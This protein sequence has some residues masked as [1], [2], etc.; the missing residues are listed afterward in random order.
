M[1][2]PIRSTH[3]D[4]V[5]LFVPDRHDAAAWYFDVLGLVPIPG[6]EHWSED[7]GGPLLISGDGGRTGLA[8][9]ASPTDDTSRG[10]FHRLAFRVSGAEFLA[11][12]EYGRGLGL[13]PMKVQDH[14]TTISVYFVDPYGHPLEVT[15]H[16][17]EV[18]R[19]AVPQQ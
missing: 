4:H 9:F 8:L 1:P 13:W 17:H 2:T 3:I 10:G 6:T 11:F 18:A 19:V 12:V 7:S 5:E 16:D 15:T 14:D